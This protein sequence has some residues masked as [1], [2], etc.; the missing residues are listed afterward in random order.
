M[1]GQGAKVFARQIYLPLTPASV[2]TGWKV[3]NLTSLTATLETPG[4]AAAAVPVRYVAGQAYVPLAGL[5]S[6]P[7]TTAQ[8]TKGTFT[9]TQAGRTTSIPLNVVTLLPFTSTP[10]YT[11]DQ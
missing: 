4:G 6:L 9:I 11:T 5:A 10:E 1:T 3:Q 8:Y 2:A 7:G